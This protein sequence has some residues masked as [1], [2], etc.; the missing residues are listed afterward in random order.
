M[1][2]V[3]NL[4]LIVTWQIS[5]FI[6]YSKVLAI[7]IEWIVWSKCSILRYAV[8]IVE[9]NGYLIMPMVNPFQFIEQQSQHMS[10]RRSSKSLLDQDCTDQDTLSTPARD[11]YLL[12]E[13]SS[14]KH[15]V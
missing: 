15:V 2:T 8:R 10:A 1:E 9:S 5:R 3:R 14:L 13:R 6:F 11:E 12:P 7:V 4:S